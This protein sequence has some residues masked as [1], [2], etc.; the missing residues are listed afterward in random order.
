M[1]PMVHRLVALLIL[2]PAV[3]SAQ[4]K[5]EDFTYWESI[6]GPLQIEA[7]QLVAKDGGDRLLLTDGVLVKG[8][9]LTIQADWMEILTKKQQVTMAGSVRIVEDTSVLLCDR[10]ELDR[11]SSIAVMHRAVIL[12]KTG[13]SADK[14]AA[15]RTASV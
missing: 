10:L 13:V 4:P 2:L 9:R 8:G 7:G 5:F 1:S 15:C 12:V 11:R 14:L 3:A 6:P